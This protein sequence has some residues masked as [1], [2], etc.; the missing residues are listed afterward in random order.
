M[1]SEGSLWLLF[2]EYL[3]IFSIRSFGLVDLVES[4]NRSASFLA[5]ELSL[6]VFQLRGCLVSGPSLLRSSSVTRSSKLRSSLVLL[7]VIAS[8]SRS[9]LCEVAYQIPGLAISLETFD[10]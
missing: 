6:P 8:L 9:D 5:V 2:E 10:R 3:R 7:V 1:V 4:L